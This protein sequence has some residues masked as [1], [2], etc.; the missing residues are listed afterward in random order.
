MLQGQNPVIVFKDGTN[1]LHEAV[2]YATDAHVKVYLDYIRSQMSPEDM[3]AVEPIDYMILNS[4]V[5]GKTALY[6][7][8]NAINRWQLQVEMMSIS[9]AIVSYGL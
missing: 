3:M 2:E 6:K 4:V 5:D 1:L 8:G 7:V 9:Y